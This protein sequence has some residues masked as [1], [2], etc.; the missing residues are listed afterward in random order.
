MSEPVDR[1][2]LG[3]LLGALD[4]SEQEWV[5]EQVA[6]NPQLREVL[7]R[8][9]ARLQLLEPS[10]GETTPPPHL[11]DATCRTVARAAGQDQAAPRARSKNGARRS[12]AASLRPQPMPAV[13]HSTSRWLD[14]AVTVGVMLALA[15]LVVPAIHSSRMQARLRGCT[16]NL[17]LLGVSLSQYSDLHNNYF[18]PVP[19][20]GKLAAAGIYAP[21]LFADG[22]LSEPH[23]VVCPDSPLSREGEFA[24]PSLS[25][26]VSASGRRLE[27]LLDRMGGSYGY[28]LGY[29][30]GGSYR[31][32]RNSFRSHFAIMA[33]A[34]SPEL[35]YRGSANHGGKF[36]NVLF[37]DGRVVTLSTCAADEVVRSIFANEVGEVAAGTHRDDAVIGHSSTCPLGVGSMRRVA[38]PLGPVE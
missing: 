13:G 29:F 16:N 33:D 11:A 35:N 22:Y 10:R 37:E 14:A 36:L 5:E 12:Q 6:E 2:L 30:E 9:K 4:E 8:L 23:R 21:K 15:L 24:M 18:P 27:E 25:E 20:E 1:L 7:V 17:R 31:P 34:P 3:Y 28:N 19:V 26:V 38:L 32:T